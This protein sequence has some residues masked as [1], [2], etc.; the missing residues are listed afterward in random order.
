MPFGIIWGGGKPQIEMY[1]A[2]LHPQC[3]MDRI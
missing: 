1:L 2:S 3:S